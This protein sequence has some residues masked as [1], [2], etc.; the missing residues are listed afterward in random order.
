MTNTLTIL[1]TDPDHA[2][3]KRFTKAEVGWDKQ[4]FDAG[5]KFR[6]IEHDVEDL[7][8]LAEAIE[9]ISPCPRAF[10]VRGGLRAEERARL[11][12]DPSATVRRRKLERDGKPPAFEEV[13]VNWLMIDIDN[14]PLPPEVD[15]ASDPDSAIRAAIRDLLPTCFHGAE[16]FWQLSASAGFTQ[17]VLKT[18]LFYWLSEPTDNITLRRFFKAT[19]PSWIPRHL[20]P[21]SHIG[22]PHRLSRAGMTHSRAALVG[23]LAMRRKS[24]CRKS[25]KM[26]ATNAPPPH[27]HEHRA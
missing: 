26:T 16:C 11:Q 4:G 8:G 15:L 25:V 3:G 10:I 9:E 13:A 22:F 19:A 7:P 21:C 17:G 20:M 24:C 23:L 1:I 14:Y 27:R 5:A 18:H 2:A 6:V 12:A